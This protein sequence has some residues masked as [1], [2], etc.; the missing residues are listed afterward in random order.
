MVSVQG[1]S[2]FNNKN[3]PNSL[4][5]NEIKIKIIVCYFVQL[6]YNVVQCF[7][8]SMLSKLILYSKVS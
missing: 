2:D 8:V 1:I 4:V 7:Y 6:E 5:I 3:D